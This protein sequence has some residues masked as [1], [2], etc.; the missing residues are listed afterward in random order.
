MVSNVIWDE[1]VHLSLGRYVYVAEL[2]HHWIRQRLVAYSLPSQYPNQGWLL[3]KHFLGSKIRW[4]KVSKL[5]Q[6]YQIDEI[7]LD[8][9]SAKFPPFCQMEDESKCVVITEK[10]DKDT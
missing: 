3:I 1:L 8:L 7:V 9:T 6:I 4:Q 5:R 2:G 10:Q